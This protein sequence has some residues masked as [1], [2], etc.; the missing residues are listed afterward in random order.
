MSKTREMARWMLGIIFVLA[1]VIIGTAVFA[2]VGGKGL[3]SI[4]ISPTT[5]DTELDINQDYYINVSTDPAGENISKFKF[6][7]DSTCVTFASVDS[8]NAILHT[9]GEGQVTIFVSKGKVESNRL[10]FTVV[11]KAARQAEEEAKKAEEEAKKAE[12]EA[13]LAEEEALKAAE[14]LEVKL[15]EVTG[16]SV[17]VRADATTESES[18]GKASKGDRYTKVEDKDGWTGIE[19]KGKTG[20]IRNDFVKVGT[21]EEL[22]EASTSDKKDDEKKEDESKKED[23]KENETKKDEKKEETKNTD[24]D[25][26]KEETKNAEDEAAKKAQEDAAKQLAE[27]QAAAAAQAPA[28]SGSLPASGPWTYG[29]ITFSASQVAYFHSL[30]DY[31]GDAAEMASHHPAGELQTLCQNSNVN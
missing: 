30:W 3:Q 24:S 1:I 21:E 10:T 23:K 25:T 31:T 9:L 22:G 27:Q 26:K 14:E 28:A 15:A 6:E 7:V 18:L 4:T 29:G 5:A 16:D 11:D 13:R 19:Y 12:E 8:S 2:L 20:Y 17:N